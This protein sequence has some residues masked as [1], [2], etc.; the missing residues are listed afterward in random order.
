MPGAR[1]AVPQPD[2]APGRRLPVDQRGGRRARRRRPPHRAR[3]G[4]ARRRVDAVDARRRRRARSGWRARDAPAPRRSA[5]AAPAARRSRRPR[6]LARV[7]RARGARRH[8]GL[9]GLVAAVL[10]AVAFAGAGAV[11]GKLA[12]ALLVGRRDRRRRSSGSPRGPAAVTPARFGVRPVEPLPGAA[13]DRRRRGAARRVLRGARA[14]LGLLAELR[15]PRELSGLDGVAWA[16]GFGEPAVPFDAAA[17]AALLARAVVGVAVLELVLRGVVL[18]A[19]ARAD[20][21]LARDRRHRRRSAP[22]RS[23]RSPA[24]GACSLPAL[25]LG[26][27][28]GPLAVATGSIVPG[29]A[30]S[31][32]FAGAALAAACGWGPL[33]AAATA[34]AAR[35]RAAARCS[36]RHGGARR[37]AASVAAPRLRGLAAERGQTAA[38][39]DGHAA[40]GRA[41]RRRARRARAPHA[42]RRTTSA[43]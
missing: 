15:V 4:R 1:K 31:A 24:T 37:A 42:D 36:P 27:L 26:A 12:A 25:A 39:Y 40:A 19:L 29:A 38:E 22:S 20:R 2:R 21:R 5:R 17:V 35:A 11:A 41:D 23:A 6:R 14:S 7:G 33:A 28:L 3:G 10:A 32:A 18:P 8:R 16:G 9:A 13:R 43:C 34:L 30:L